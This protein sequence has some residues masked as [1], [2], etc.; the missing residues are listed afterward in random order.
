MRCQPKVPDSVDPLPQRGG[1]SG[2]HL[3]VGSGTT[4]L[5]PSTFPSAQAVESN[6]T[7]GAAFFCCL[8]E[9]NEKLKCME[10]Q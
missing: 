9:G 8:F 5:S 10:I 1:F 3:H 6:V 4:N 2:A 7:F